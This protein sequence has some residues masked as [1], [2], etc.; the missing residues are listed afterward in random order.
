MRTV[1]TSHGHDSCSV[2]Y[3][4]R[5]TDLLEDRAFIRKGHYVFEIGFDGYERQ[6]C[7]GLA[8]SG[9][10]LMSMDDSVDLIDIIRKEYK[11]FKREQ[12]K[13]LRA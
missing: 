6:L 2:V 1:F 7:K 3:E 5:L 9:I 4:D 8:L 12:S 13:F 10:T 11:I